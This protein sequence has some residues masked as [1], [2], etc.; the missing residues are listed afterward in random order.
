MA[1]E[2]FGPHEREFTA[3]LEH[4]TQLHHGEADRAEQQAER[5]QTLKR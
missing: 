5:A 3:S 1:V 4:A 2:A